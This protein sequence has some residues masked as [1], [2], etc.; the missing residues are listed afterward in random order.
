MKSVQLVLDARPLVG[1]AA[2][3]RPYDDALVLVDKMRQRAGDL[4]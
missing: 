2:P 1:H 3:P 4:Q